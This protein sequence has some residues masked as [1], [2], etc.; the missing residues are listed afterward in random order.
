M[1]ILTNILFVSIILTALILIII[2]TIFHE[3][4]I[5]IKDM[6]KT[7]I[8]VF[9]TSLSVLVL[10]KNGTLDKQVSEVKK[11]E[12]I[13]YVFNELQNTNPMP[14]SIPVSLHTGG[15][16]FALESIPIIPPV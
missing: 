6:V 13:D 3:Y 5:E 15:N 12:A 1:E 11:T 16:E 7:V 9:I 8:Y 10:Y 4:D 14:L 2:H